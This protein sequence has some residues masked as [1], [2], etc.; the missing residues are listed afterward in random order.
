MGHFAPAA[1]LCTL[2]VCVQ[3]LA[4]IFLEV[5]I[6]E[7]IEK[8]EKI[9]VGLVKWQSNNVFVNCPPVSLTLL[10]YILGVNHTE[11]CFC[12]K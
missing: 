9:Q 7:N 11:W 2:C 1:F 5:E 10:G 3:K 4:L 6:L 8:D 12:S